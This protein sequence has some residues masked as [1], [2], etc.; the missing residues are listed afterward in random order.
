MAHSACK[1][2]TGQSREFRPEGISESG[3]INLSQPVFATDSVLP[4]ARASLGKGVSH[5]KLL[6]IETACSGNIWL[7]AGFSLNVALLRRRRDRHRR[8]EGTRPVPDG[9]DRHPHAERGQLEFPRIFSGPGR[10]AQRP[11]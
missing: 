9:D 1:N 6:D 3:A 8:A 11:A 7:S 4:Q 5:S 10:E 2:C